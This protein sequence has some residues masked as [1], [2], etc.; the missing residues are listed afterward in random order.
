MRTRHLAAPGAR[1]AAA[2][3]AAALVAVLALAACD[4]PVTSLASSSAGK[5]AARAGESSAPSAEQTGPPTG[6]DVL[7]WWNYAEERNTRDLV[8]QLFAQRYPGARYVDRWVDGEEYSAQGMMDRIERDHGLVDVYQPRSDEA[9][10][11]DDDEGRAEDVTD[12]Y[13]EGL[14][15]ALP[16]GVI[17]L[18][19][20]DGR[21]YRVP[22]VVVRGNMLWSDR[23]VLTASGLDPDAAYP[24]VDAW[25]T[26][27]RK[28]RAAGRTPLTLGAWW[29]H[30]L[31]LDDVLLA[32]LGRDAY[33]G[34]WDGST[35]WAGAP[36]VAA[37]DDFDT[38]VRLAGEPTL[39]DDWTPQADR[40][41]DHEVAFV[42]MGD[43]IEPHLAAA[44]RVL[45]VDYGAA[46]MPGTDGSFMLGG[47]DAGTFAMRAGGPHPEG[48]R[49]W[50]R[51]VSSPEAQA[52]IAR[53]LGLLP[54]RTDVDPSGF[55][56]YTRDALVH[57]REDVTVSSSTLGG[58]V[59]PDVEVAI[60]EAG[61]R[62]VRHRTG[63]DGLRRAM[64]RAVR[65]GR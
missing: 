39:E 34:L 24:S 2:V 42:V 35:D 7:T 3:T 11:L 1:R 61:D 5:G 17:D 6:V 22:L 55:D 54:A 52:Q 49:A 62:Y 30:Q 10:L 59:G 27:L 58:V 25:I 26:A 36:V 43:W 29:T 38:I 51:L 56:Q 65:A 41:V 18:L 40:L 32:E 4:G 45:G 48:A 15:G 37:F 46:A 33:A 23:Q 12:L 31:L 53:S 13:D 14:R 21:I 47:L 63:V 64:A 19:P 28:V 60:Q 20:V 50:L 44:H 57:L 9:W 16:Q 8:E